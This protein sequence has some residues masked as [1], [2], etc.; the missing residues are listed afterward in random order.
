MTTAPASADDEEKE[1]LQTILEDNKIETEI[2]DLVNCLQQEAEIAEGKHP[3][4]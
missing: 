1:N 2:A 3:L 4:N